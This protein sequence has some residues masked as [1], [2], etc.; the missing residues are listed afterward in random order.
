MLVELIDT[1]FVN[2]TTI[3]PP[4]AQSFISPSVFVA[5]SLCHLHVCD[6]LKFGK[7]CTKIIG[8]RS[9]LGQDWLVGGSRVGTGISPDVAS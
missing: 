4:Y 3:P 1:V 8:G 6:G 5:L 9:G 7:V 2:S